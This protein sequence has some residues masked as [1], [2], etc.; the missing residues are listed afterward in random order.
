MLPTRRPSP[1]TLGLWLLI[2]AGACRMTT[3]RAAAEDSNVAGTWTWSWKD[4]AG[5]T[6][7]HLLEVEGVDTKL[8]GREEF[9]DDGPIPVRDLR[10]N[11][12]EIRFTVI[13]DKRRADYYGILADRDTINGTVKVTVDGETTEYPWMATR[14][15]AP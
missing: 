7:R 1:L 3:A 2:I 8:A 12:K 10:R 14:K 11:G 13:R 4:T 15:P 5:Q 9:D 6:H